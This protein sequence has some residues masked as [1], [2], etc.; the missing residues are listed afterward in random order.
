M[1]I[2]LQLTPETEARLSAAAN[3][4]GMSLDVYVKTLIEDH[5]RMMA[6][7]RPSAA[8]FRALLD[9]IAAHS[10]KIPA[11]P[12]NAFISREDIYQ[13]HD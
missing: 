3:A 2:N 4:R 8:E 12:D 1:V 13:D 10:D 6:R 5:S 11:L 7:Q 9:A